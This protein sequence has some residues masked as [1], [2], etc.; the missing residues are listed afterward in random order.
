MEEIRNWNYK[1]IMEQ[2]RN[3]DFQIIMEHTSKSATASYACSI[4]VVAY[5]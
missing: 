4:L 2:T 1:I 3:L 5:D